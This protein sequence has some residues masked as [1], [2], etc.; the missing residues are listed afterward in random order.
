[1]NTLTRVQ[2]EALAT[3]VTRLRPDWRHAGVV[4]AIEK[5]A[6]TADAFDVAR[7][8]I[9]LAAEP[10]VQTPG[11]LPGKGPHWRRPDGELP[12]RRGDHNVYCHRH[13]LSVL[14]NCPQCIAEDQPCRPPADLME[15]M[16][17]DV[18]RGKDAV[19]HRAADN[20]AR[21]AAQP[22]DTAA[23]DAARDRI[24]EEETTS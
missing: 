18:R 12:D 7:A 9:N 19:A 21:R 8:L 15:Q 10:S 24:D 5:A 14:P 4:A 3:L 2:T 17:A 23:V 20:E 6:A 13:P 11:L 22:T 1:M 16:L